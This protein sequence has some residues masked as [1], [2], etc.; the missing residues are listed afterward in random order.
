[1]RR[2]AR[3]HSNERGAAAVE[4]AMVAGLL[5]L[6]VIGAFEWGMALRDWMTV[7]SA[8][9]EG[10]RAAAS[11]GSNGQADCA[12]LEAVAGALQNIPS[13]DVVEVVIYE[14]DTAG[15]FGLAQRYRSVRD[16]DPVSLTCVGEWYQLGNAWPPADRED[17]GNDRDWVGVRVIF[18]HHWQTGFLWFSGSSRWQDD[19]VMRIEPQVP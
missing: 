3:N 18:D 12:V 14:S 10:A 2:A 11:A 9:R 8:T 19:T 15:S 17:T 4:T 7:S 5:L 16:S 6:L 1:M 13:E